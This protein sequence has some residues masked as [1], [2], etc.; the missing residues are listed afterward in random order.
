MALKPASRYRHLDHSRQAAR[1]LCGTRRRSP[2]GRPGP[3]PREAHGRDLGHGGLV[4][5]RRWQGRGAPAPAPRGR[6]RASPPL[7]ASAT[8]APPPERE[9]PSIS[10]RTAGGSSERTLSTSAPSMPWMPAAPGDRRVDAG[11]CAGGLAGFILTSFSVVWP[12]ASGHVL[13]LEVDDRTPISSISTWRL[14][15]LRFTNGIEEQRLQAVDDG[16]HRPDILI[17]ARF[18]CRSLARG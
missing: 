14:R 5:L 1:G 7:S 2:A 6:R 3:R 11:A 16:L 4:D 9:L 13:A 18:L 12:L 17:L 15:S 8:F 10:A